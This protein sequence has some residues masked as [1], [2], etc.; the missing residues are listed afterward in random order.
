MADISKTLARTDKTSSLM[1][2]K[3]PLRAALVADHGLVARKRKFLAGVD[4][5]NG[6]P[7]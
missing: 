5:P 7:P 1:Q 3:N 2:R 4:K 6:S